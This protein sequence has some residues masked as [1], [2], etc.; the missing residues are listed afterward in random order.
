MP[1]VLCGTVEQLRTWRV[2]FFSAK[3]KHKSSS[4]FL[5]S[6]IQSQRNGI[7][8]GPKED[9]HLDVV[10]DVEMCK[11]ICPRRICIAGDEA[12]EYRRWR[13]DRD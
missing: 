8:A 2:H 3:Q 6:S 12:E 13:C 7:T 10:R 4:Y 5:T 11:P 9:A 1:M